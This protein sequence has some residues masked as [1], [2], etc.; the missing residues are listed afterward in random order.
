MWQNSGRLN[1]LKL[2]TMRQFEHDERLMRI[3]LD[4]LFS[5]L[6]K[7]MVNKVT[8]VGLRGKIAPIA[9]PWIRPC[10]RSYQI[11]AQTFFKRGKHGARKGYSLFLKRITIQYLVRVIV[12]F[13]KLHKQ[14]SCSLVVFCEKPVKGA[15]LLGSSWSD[16]VVIWVRGNCTKF[17]REKHLGPIIESFFI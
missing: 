4:R 15:L 8:F 7:I 9:S 2:L 3:G 13:L 10:K 6:Y 5:E 17:P 14:C 11:W 1:G 12:F 16:S